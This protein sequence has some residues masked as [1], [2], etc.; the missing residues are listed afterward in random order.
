MGKAV[1][2]K[3]MT[4]AAETLKDPVLS[5]YIVDPIGKEVAKELTNI[6]STKE[7][8][9]L[10]S[11][12]VAQLKLCSWDVLLHVQVAAT[13]KKILTCATKIQ[14]TRSNTNAVIGI[15]SAILLNH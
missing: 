14:I 4:I 6:A 10:Q 15:C 11:Q 7:E 8:S 9:V 3:K 1:A 2:R 5:G 13:L 12:D